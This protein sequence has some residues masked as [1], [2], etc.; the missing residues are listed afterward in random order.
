MVVERFQITIGERQKAD[1][2]FSLIALL[3]L[4]LQIHGHFSCNQRLEIVGRFQS[5]HLHVIVHHNQLMLQISSGKRATLHLGNAAVFQVVTQH[6]LH[7]NPDAAFALT[8]VAFQQHHGLPA[9]SG[10]NAIAEVLLQ[11]KNVLV[12]QKFR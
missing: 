10:K 11:S 9:V 6:L 5:L 3:A 2:H 12:L 4:A 7:H 8:A 1:V